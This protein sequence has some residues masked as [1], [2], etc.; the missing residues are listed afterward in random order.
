MDNKVK[1]ACVV[2]VVNIV[3]GFLAMTVVSQL[4][5]VPSLIIS[6]IAVVDSAMVITRSKAWGIMM[7]IINLLGLTYVS[8]PLLLA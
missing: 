3:I 6:I 8:S 5:Y 2:T 1:F 7:L 4:W